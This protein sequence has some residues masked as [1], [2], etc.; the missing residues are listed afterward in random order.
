MPNH[1]QQTTVQESTAV[2]WGSCLMEVGETVGALVNVGALRDVVW[3]ETFDK[4]SVE[5]DNAGP[6]ELGIRNHK[7][8]ISGNWMELN[9]DNLAKVYA[10]VHT[11]VAANTTPKVVTDE[12]HTLNDYDSEALTHKNGANTEVASITVDNA[13]VGTLEYVRDCDYI[14]VTLPDGKTAIARA[15]VVSV[16]AGDSDISVV[17]DGGA[18]SDY[19]SDVGTGLAE[20]LAPGDHIYVTGYADAANN[21]VHEVVTA[22]N[23]KIIVNE[24]LATEAAV[25]GGIS[26]DRGVIQDGAAVFVN[27][28]YTP[29]EKRTYTGGGFSTFTPQVV[30]ITNSDTSTPAKTLQCT[31]FSATPDG[32]IKIDFPSD[33]EV[34]PSMVPIKMNGRLD[35]DLT[36]GEQLFEIV[37]TQQTA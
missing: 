7:C 34:D 31:I 12:S 11:K 20:V 29:L 36:S 13:A 21:G 32:G 19:Y 17:E 18:G 3:E 23:N 5:T 6:I 1:K 33:D 14:V 25:V 28:T 8:A 26:I 24:I 35:N 27:Y 22:A 30:R 2:K 9:W 15:L 37:D 10:G 4:V 16:T